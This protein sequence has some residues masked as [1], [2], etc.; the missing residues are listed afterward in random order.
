MTKPASSEER[1][2]YDVPEAG[3]MLGLTRNGSYAAAKRGDLPTIRIGGLIKVPKAAFHAMLE[4][5]QK[6]AS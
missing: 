2:V 3:A 1:L 5:T 4:G 6:Q